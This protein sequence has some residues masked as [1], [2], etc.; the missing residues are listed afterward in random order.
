MNLVFPGIDDRVDPPHKLAVLVDILMEEGITAEDALAGSGISPAQVLDPASRT[1]ARQ[2]LAVCS[3]ALRL[4]CDPCIAIKAG[5]RIHITHLGLYG[6]ALLSSS[7]P[8]DAIEFAIKYRPLAAPL[9]GLHFYED[10]DAAVWEFSDVLSLGVDSELFRFVLEFQLGTQLSLHSDIL[11]Q[12]VTPSEIMLAF[13]P[14]GHASAYEELLGCPAL[15]GQSNNELRFSRQW[16]EKKLTFANPIT[17]KLVR[18]TCD[19]LL[20]ELKMSSGIVGQ[21]FRMLMEQPGRF[22][23]IEIIATQLNLTSRTL[24][25]KLT[26]QDSS[27]QTILTDVR[28]QLAIDYLRKT[29]M[30]IEDIA[31]SLGFSDSANFRHAFKKWTGKT[32]SD[33]RAV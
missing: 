32:P 25:R 29:R 8:S 2:L 14:P 30:S 20:A 24:R 3:N 26:T 21:V 15:F 4:S 28:K 1:S 33:F 11:G 13:S 19:Q 27:Y 16:M 5:K 31:S 22:P 6:F 17:A 18:E 7:T 10:S 9:I 23:S 12:P